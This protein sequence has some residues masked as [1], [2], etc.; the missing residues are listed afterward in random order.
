V[1]MD[2]YQVVFDQI[3]DKNIMQYTLSEGVDRASLILDITEGLGYLHSQSVIH[4]RLRGAAILVNDDGRAVL[5]DFG[6]CSVVWNPE[7]TSRWCAPE[8]LGG[9]GVSGTWPTYSSDVFSF[10]MVV[11]EIFSG[12]QPFDGVPDDDVIK[13]VRSGERP[14]RPAGSANLGLSDTLW[15]V[16]QKC[17]NGSPE[18]RPGMVD[19]LE[20]TGKARPTLGTEYSEAPTLI[21]PNAAP[22]ANRWKRYS[23]FIRVC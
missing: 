20:Y 4:G 21:N 11:L 13:L 10:G 1:T 19:V 2:P 7:D 5:T 15:E 6:S 3:S 14:D 12:K 16:V 22:K 18:L 9:G 8:V 23:N 17:W